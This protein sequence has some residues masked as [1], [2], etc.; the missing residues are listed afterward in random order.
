MTTS[1]LRWGIVATGCAVSPLR[2]PPRSHS[3]HLVLGIQV[4]QHQVLPRP[5][6]RPAHARRHR[7]QACHRGCRVPI[8]GK[9]RAVRQRCLEGGWRDYRKGGRE[10]LRKLRRDLC[11]QGELTEGGASGPAG[12]RVGVWGRFAD[13]DKLAGRRRS[14][15]W[16]ASLE[17][18]PELC[19]CAY[20]RQER[21]LREVARCQR[22]AGSRSRRSCSIQGDPNLRQMASRVLTPKHF[23]TERL[24]HGG[25]LD[26]LPACLV[27]GPGGP[28]Q[29]RYRR[30]SFGPGGAVCE[31]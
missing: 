14:V 12:G 29:R 3:R 23:L 24:L 27:Q 15:H 6:L 18:L 20:C 17:P 10:A 31:P 7:C 13:G 11:E 4:D 1:T 9:G 21:T 19:S 22:G 8:G 30:A 26:P 28:S 5:P 25:R 2:R 16:D